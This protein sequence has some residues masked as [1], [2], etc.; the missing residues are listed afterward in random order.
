MI[1]K[2]M[3]RPDLIK[4]NSLITNRESLVYF[5]RLRPKDMSLE[6]VESLVP[7]D[8]DEFYVEKII[9]HTRTSMNPKEEEIFNSLE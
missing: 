2:V 6:K 9:G 3:D 5:S 4:V 1:I 8:P 7:A